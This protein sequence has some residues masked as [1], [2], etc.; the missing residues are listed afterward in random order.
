MEHTIALGGGPAGL[1]AAYELTK[2]GAPVTVLERFDRVGGLSRTIP[3]NG[4]LFDIGPHRFFTKNDEVR[5]LFLDITGDDALVVPRLTRILYQNR[6]FNY[7]VTPVNALV[8]LGP[9]ECA[10]IL[11]SYLSAAARK[12]TATSEPENFAEWMTDKFGSRL[13]QLFF[14]TYTEKVW[15]IPCTQIGADWARQRIKGLSLAEAL[16]HALFTQGNTVKS[17]VNEFLF[18]RLGAGQLYEKMAL[19]IQAR[20]GSIETNRQVI[21]IRREGATVR[22]IIARNLAGEQE[23]WRAGNVLSSA[24]LTET[25]QMMDPP[26]P[27]E[28]LQACRS[29]RYRNH[30]GVHLKLKGSPFPDNWIYIHSK[31]VKMARI[32]NYRNFS[33]EMASSC[34]ISPITIEYFSSA[35]DSLARLSD[36]ELLEHASRE[37][38]QTGLLKRNFEIIS[39]F[40]VRSEKAYPVIELGFERHVETIRTWL[41]Q[42]TNLIPIGR[43]GM[44]K[45]NNQD[46]AIATGLLGARNILGFAKYDPW[47]VNIDAEYHEEIQ[48]QPSTPQV[49]VT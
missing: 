19:L 43:S 48:F 30:L 26:P 23:E 44:F 46:H 5:Q 31:N 17:L 21:R 29:L 41:D 27:D 40:V 15:G 14:Q 36:N 6:F 16:R 3:H 12:L 32:S 4:C 39:G 35:G 10:R 11:T 8:G 49:Q 20:G 45:Y 38:K 25:V 24:P 34:D 33:P 22:A 7:P 28:V 9:V 1:S 13:F 37:M 42:F 2:H 18:P 47:L